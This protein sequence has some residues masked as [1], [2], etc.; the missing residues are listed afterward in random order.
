MRVLLVNANRAREL[1][2]VPPIGLAYVAEAAWRAGHQVEVLDLMTS[3]RPELAVATAVARLQPEVVGISVRNLD[4]IAHQRLTYYL[5]EVGA[6]IDRLRATTTVPIVLGGPAISVLGGPVLNHLKAD[7]AV[8]GDGEDAFVRL[9]QA[10]EE[11]GEPSAVPNLCH[12]TQAGIVETHRATCERLGA[13]GLERWVRWGPYGRFGA[14]WPIQTKR[15]CP[16]GCRYCAY[17]AVEGHLSR[18]RDPR[19]VADEIERVARTVGPRAFEIV[20]SA[21]NVPLDAALGVCEEIVRRGLDVHLTTAS[22]NPGMVT[23]ELLALMKRAGF[24]SLMLSPDA[25]SDMTLEALGKGFAVTDVAR[26]AALVRCSGLR[27]GWFFM[28]GGP[29]ETIETADETMRFIEQE[30]AWPR[31]LVIVTTGI[32]LLPGTALA[33]LAVRQGMLP[34]DDDLVRPRFYFSPEVREAELLQRVNQ[35]IASHPGIVHTAEQGRSPVSDIR[36]W[37]LYLAGQAPPYWRFYPEFLRMWPLRQLRA[38]FPLVGPAP[39]ALK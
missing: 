27:S 39:P 35:G 15:G 24:N 9:L 7:Y 21:F 20:D 37:V 3:R 38:R 32:R 1:L 8:V 29:G 5:D 31:C 36:D 26:A 6:L 10:L 33:S 2:A 12:R 14:T 4:N 18:R 17:H 25:A 34:P 22:V 23:A 16:L 11:G 30:L 13:S 19:E 28:L